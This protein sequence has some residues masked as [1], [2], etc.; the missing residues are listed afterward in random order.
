MREDGIDMAMT[1]TGMI[2]I[3]MTKREKIT[4]TKREKISVMAETPAAKTT[5]ASDA[6]LVL[7]FR[8]STS[9]L[10]RN[11]GLS[12]FFPAEMNISLL[13]EGDCDEDMD[14]ERGLVS[15]STI[16]TILPPDSDTSRVESTFLK[17]CGKDNCHAWGSGFDAT[18]DCC[19]K[20]PS[21]K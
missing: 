16:E 6:E 9:D 21:L 15:P 14:C 2:G 4:M 13:G 11:C 12:V 18:D 20:V 5:Q 10:L 8:H 7:I 1:K 3:T 17:V 19:R